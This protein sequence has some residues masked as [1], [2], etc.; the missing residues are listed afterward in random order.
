MQKLTVIFFSEK[1]KS[2]PIFK[3]QY[4]TKFQL[5]RAKLIFNFQIYFF[6]L[7]LLISTPYTHLQSRACLS[8]LMSWDLCQSSIFIIF[9][10]VTD[11]ERKHAGNPGWPWQFSIPFLTSSQQMSYPIWQS[12][13]LP[14]WWEMYVGNVLAWFFFFF[15]FFF[16]Y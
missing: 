2:Y 5:V 11:K 12:L 13:P 10:P 8:G 16:L 1:K 9:K 6:L 15:F 3:Y 14:S 7:P 4:P